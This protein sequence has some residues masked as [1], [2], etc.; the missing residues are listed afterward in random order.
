MTQKKTIIQFEIWTE[1]DGLIDSSGNASP[2]QL[3]KLISRTDNVG[4][5]AL[6][7]EVHE[8]HFSPTGE[9]ELEWRGMEHV[10]WLND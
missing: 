10:S 4:R 3:I 9:L 6:F 5:R 2:E 1:A 8:L 7:A